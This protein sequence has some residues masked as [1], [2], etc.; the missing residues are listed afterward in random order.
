MFDYASAATPILKEVYLP[1]IQELLP[2]STPL[3][4]QIEKEIT[5]VEGGNFVVSVHRQRNSAAAIGRAENGTLPTAGKQGFVRA[6]VPIKLL[7]SRIAV[8]GKAIAATKSNKGS[9]VRA[10]DSEMQYVMKDTKRGLNR[11]LNGDGTGALA[12][13]TAADNNVVDGVTL[14]DGLGNGTTH[15]P[16]GTSTLELIDA[17][18]HT[19][20]LNSTALTITRGAVG[21]TSTAA[22]GTGT[23]AGTA[24]GDYLVWPGTRGN[25]IVGIQAVI[26][27]ANPPGMSGGLHG[28]PVATYP[29]WKAVVVGS[30]SSREDFSFPKLQQLLSRITTEGDVDAQ[31]IKFLHSHTAMRD[32]YV[33][34]AQ[35]QRV[36][37]NTMKLDGGW[38]VVTYN[39]KPWSDDVQ[40]RRNAIFAITPSSLRLMQMAPLDW[41]DKDGSIFYR[42][43]GGNQDAYGATLFGYMELGCLARNQNGVYL[44]IN[45]VWS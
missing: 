36:F 38:E 7:Y 35:D 27:D 28:L 18:D 14:D 33:K 34:A 37:H 11:Q 42:L 17:S 44:G 19:T 30:D 32:T 21:A 4:K 24:D 22:T 16:I 5:P 2:N 23:V 45:E 40:C 8:S 3:L 41:M 6:I 20:V 9:F 43:D 31:D 1:Q 39:G 25:E 10:L 15:L 13:W 12:Y 26:S 29:D